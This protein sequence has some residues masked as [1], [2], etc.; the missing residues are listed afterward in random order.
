M[1]STLPVKQDLK[2]LQKILQVPCE[3]LSWK[4]SEQGVCSTKKKKG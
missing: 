3:A 4:Q 1:A 2:A